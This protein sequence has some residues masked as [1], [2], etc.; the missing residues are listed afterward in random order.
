MRLAVTADLHW[1][2]RPRGD[3]AT[4]ALA[5]RAAELAPDAFVIAG[6]VGDG[7]NFGACL[8]CFA[9]VPGE[10]LF[11]PGNHDLWTSGPQISSLDV[12]ERR[13]PS[14]AAERGFRVLD[15]EPFV[16]ADGRIA[17]LGSVN[18]YDYSYADPELAKE[19]PDVE[20]MYR[21]KLFPTG[22]HNDGRFVHLGMS[23][24]EF[25]G[26]LVDRFR[27]QLAA[28]PGRVEQVIVIQHHPPI[29]ELFYPSELRTVAQR[30]WL[31][32]TGNRRMQDA[33]LA[34]TRVTTIICGHTHAACAAVVDGRR[35]LNVGGDYEWKRLLLL[36]TESGEETA[37]EFR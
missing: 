32:Y 27:A 14:M 18:W 5:R 25:T 11:V 37:Y 2:L 19:I 30:V 4:R 28:L 6:D 31:A 35:C 1:G 26:V 36:D 16:T 12:Y 33:V 9:D 15:F 3:A 29:R 24:E 17:V 22:R 8:D 13:I 21:A 7:A 23:D 20:A 34:D 10:R